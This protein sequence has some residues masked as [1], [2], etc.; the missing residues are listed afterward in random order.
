MQEIMENA[1]I[2]YKNG[3]REI[4]DAISIANKGVYTGQIRQNNKEIGFINHSYVP[5]DQIEK[6]LVFNANG[7]SKN[8]NFNKVIGRK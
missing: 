5:N 3:L 7:E 6:I 2:I 8:I 4:F 1:T